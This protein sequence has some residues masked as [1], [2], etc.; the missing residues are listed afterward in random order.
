L[1]ILS[2]NNAFGAA[3]ASDSPRKGSGGTQYVLC[4]TNCCCVPWKSATKD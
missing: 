2:S 3:V 4:P 1:E